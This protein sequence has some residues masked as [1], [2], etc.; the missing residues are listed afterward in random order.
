MMILPRPDRIPISLAIVTTFVGLVVMLL[1]SVLT[2]SYLSSLRNTLGLVG[3]LAV[4]S[5]CSITGSR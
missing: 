4:Q 3:E 1:G 2:V 5:A